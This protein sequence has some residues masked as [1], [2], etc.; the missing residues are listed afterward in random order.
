MVNRMRWATKP[1]TRPGWY[2]TGDGYGYAEIVKVE[3][4]LRYGALVAHYMFD[5]WEYLSQLRGDLWA[6]PIPEP[7]GNNNGE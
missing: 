4:H 2:W 7:G 5:E 6:G 1:P 3:H